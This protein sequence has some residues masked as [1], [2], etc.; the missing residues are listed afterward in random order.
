M[1]TIE[2]FIK[3]NVTIKADEA[4]C[5]YR[6]VAEGEDG[7]IYN[8]GF[9]IK[10]SGNGTYELV[11]WGSPDHIFTPIK[12]V[13]QNRTHLYLHTQLGVFGLEITI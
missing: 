2:D 11:T 8:K 3:G 13:S 9:K 4:D 7:L 5:M 6:F 12:A 1:K 10:S